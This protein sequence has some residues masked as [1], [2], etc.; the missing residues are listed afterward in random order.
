MGGVLASKYSLALHNASK[1]KNVMA[2]VMKDVELLQSCRMQ[3][4][5][6]REF[7]SNPVVSREVERK[8]KRH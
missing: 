3:N 8:H 1:S 2:A 6:F 7:L 5:S 4:E